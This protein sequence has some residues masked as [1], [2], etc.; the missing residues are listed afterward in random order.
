MKKISVDEQAIHHCGIDVSGETLVVAVQQENQKFVHRSFENRAS[1]HKELVGWL[2]KRRGPVQVS[3]EA[4]GVYSL[5]LA[6][7]LDGAQGIEVAV[8]NPKV[9]HRFAETIRR[10]KTDAADAEVLAEY[11]RRMPFVVWS[12]PSRNSLRLRTVS[13]YID[14]LT[15]QHT[16]ENNRLHAAQASTSTHRCVVQDLKRSLASIER[17][18]HKLRRQ[19]LLLVRSDE[20][21]RQRF[22]LL[23]G[24]PGIAAVS[25]IQILS[26]VLL[27][28]PD[29]TA[30]EWVA[31]SG[32]DPAHQVSGTSVRKPSRISRAG[33]RHLRRALYMP[34][35]VAVRLDPHLKD[36]YE[37]L[38]SRHKARL[39]ALVAV[40]RKLLHAIYGIFRSQT[41]Y[42]GHKLFPALGC[43]LLLLP[44]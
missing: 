33:N 15:V 8:L 3:L 20:G 27:L 4:T 7:A 12:A 9:F 30:R 26:E 24:I 43:T 18:I 39:Q 11:T 22:D 16:R 35:L 1:G 23:V 2:Q 34:A 28:P 36:F 32:L 17:R 19:A 40:S 44:T 5:D 42:E 38:L 29:L 13:R 41:P 10:S 25:A 37:R 14:S 21:I 31:H 6:L